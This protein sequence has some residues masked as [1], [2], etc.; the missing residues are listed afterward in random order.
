MPHITYGLIDAVSKGTSASTNETISTLHNRIRSLLPNYETFLQGSYANDTAIADINDVDIVAIANP[1]TAILTAR[2][3]ANNLF[4]SIRT[5]LQQG[6]NYGE[7]ITVGRKCLTVKLSTKKADVVPAIRA[8]T[9]LN[10]FN[11]PILIANQIANYP[12]THKER[13]FTKNKSTNGSYKKVVRMIKNYVNNWGIKASAPSF[14]LEC[15]I[16]SYPDGWFGQELPL[17]MLSIL[18]HMCGERFNI[19]FTSIAGDKLIVSQYEWQPQAFFHFKSHVANQIPWLNS[20]VTA[21]DENN[22]N[23]SFRKFFNI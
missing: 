4:N 5:A 8:Q 15:L 14:Y 23:Y 22:A 10:L 2:G 17:A 1:M 21:P 7:T 6:L 18:R 3:S 13:G 19:N 20:S 9:N 11:E 16:Y 12:K